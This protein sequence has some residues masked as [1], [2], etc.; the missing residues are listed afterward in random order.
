MEPEAKHVIEASG[1]AAIYAVN[2]GLQ[3]GPAEPAE[4]L[5]RGEAR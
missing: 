3:H 4:K 5:T 2:G 1:G